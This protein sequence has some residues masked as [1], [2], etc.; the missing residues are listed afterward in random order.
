MSYCI[1]LRKS[2]ADAEAEAH[3][4]GETLARHERI[5]TDLAKRM[6]LA[7]DAVYREIV[8][9][10]SIAARPVMQRLLSEVGAGM[11]EGVLVAEVERLARGDTADQGLV[12]QTFKYSDTKIITPTKTYNPNNEFDEEYF[13]FGLFMSRREYKTINRRLQQGRVASIN[14]GKFVGNKPPYGYKRVK[15]E[16]EKGF[17]LE[18][19]PEEAEIVRSIFS[20]YISGDGAAL[21]STRL[22]KLHV[23]TYKGGPWS[24]ATIMSILKNPV[25]TGKVAWNRR[26]T[27]KHMVNGNVVKSRPRAENYI[28]KN[29]LH[30]AIITD[31][32]FAAA[33]SSTVNRRHIPIPLRK[34]VRN[35]LV[36][37]I[38]CGICGHN[39]FRKAASGQA[40][41]T[42]LLCKTYGC[43][44]VSS[45][46]S[47]VEDAVIE[48]IRKWLK[49]HELDEVSVEAALHGNVGVGKASLTGVEKDIA[50]TEAQREKLYDLLEK[51]I[52]TEEVFSRRHELLTTRLEELT[53]AKKRIEDEIASVASEQEKREYIQKVK[54]TLS[55][56]YT[57]SSPAER[58][59]A[60]KSILSKAVYTK[61]VRFGNFNVDV[62]PNIIF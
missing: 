38:E 28:L 53:L 41:N 20:S 40:K 8:S 18:P 4:E 43:N 2:R 16:H 56:Y 45:E 27:E 49:E 26:K 10:E 35:P 55:A 36:G 62:F 52:Y 46:I 3:G 32:T 39:M 30:E 24:G 23:P 15:L 12:A 1:Y 61:T 48:A 51:G 33:N 58:N 19:V 22:N 7:V 44:C 25:Y 14:E 9:G 42:I 6:N 50:D 17:T 34:E 54:R 29:G 31:E 21:I 11:W 57:L 59:T 13:E 60:L 37:L 5:L 47:L